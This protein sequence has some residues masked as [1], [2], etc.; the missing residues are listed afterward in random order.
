MYLKKKEMI[1]NEVVKLWVYNLYYYLKNVFD[2]N[3][4]FYFKFF[5]YFLLKY[6][7]VIYVILRNEFIL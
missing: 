4:I 2:N 1:V 7:F 5:L 6:F 3:L